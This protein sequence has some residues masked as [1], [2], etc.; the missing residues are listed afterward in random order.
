MSTSKIT[1]PASLAMQ[2][3]A[4]DAEEAAYRINRYVA[5]GNALE[6][7]VPKAI[8]GATV[9]ELRDELLAQLPDMD[10]TLAYRHAVA[11][12][13]ETARSQA[14]AKRTRTILAAALAGYP[15]NSWLR[16]VIVD[17]APFSRRPSV[18][19][20]SVSLTIRPDQAGKKTAL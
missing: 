13:T 19:A 20:R 2:R 9:L 7:L 12:H 11:L 16:P 18:F 4:L 10:P 1:N 6:A 14:A 5:T 15:R 17:A 3:L 8:D